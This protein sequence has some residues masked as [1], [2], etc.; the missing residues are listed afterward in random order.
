MTHFSDG[1]LQAYLDGEL[2]QEGTREM[3][4]HLLSCSK[5]I[6]ALNQ[7]DIAG[8]VTTCALTALDTLPQL[9]HPE[10]NQKSDCARSDARRQRGADAAGAG[11]GFS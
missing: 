2:T 10:K 11:D 7:L 3:E 6:E 4:G 5:C 9:E 1:E 8:R